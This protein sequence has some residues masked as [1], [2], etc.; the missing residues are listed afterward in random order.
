MLLR[1]HLSHQPEDFID[2]FT[3]ALDITIDTPLQKSD[4]NHTNFTIPE[5][6]CLPVTG[7]QHKSWT[8]HMWIQAFLH[9]DA[10]IK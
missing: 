8:L 3:L 9:K 10:T 1:M 7:T 5:S 4:A 6:H 2:L